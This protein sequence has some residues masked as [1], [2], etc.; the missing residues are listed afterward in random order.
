MIFLA[1]AI[2]DCDLLRYAG[3]LFR[4]GVRLSIGDVALASEY[5]EVEM[6]DLV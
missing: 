2:E 1:I 6:K 4:E 5:L 3:V